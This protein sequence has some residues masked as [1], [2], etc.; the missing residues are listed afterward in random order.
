MLP[1]LVRLGRTGSLALHPPTMAPAP[2]SCLHL[3]PP[4]PSSPLPRV[5]SHHDT[6][7]RVLGRE[8]HLAHVGLEVGAVDH[9]EARGLPRLHQVGAPQ[10][11]LTAKQHLRARRGR[12]HRSHISGTSVEPQC[13]A[14]RAALWLATACSCPAAQLPPLD[15]ARL[16]QP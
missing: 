3:P 6:H 14:A 2:I 13:R 8:P 11:L 16:V 15:W 12:V 5:R 4:P 7:L 1:P 10:V 9:P